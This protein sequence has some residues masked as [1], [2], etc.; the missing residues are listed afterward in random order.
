MTLWQFLC[1]G[2]QGQKSQYCNKKTKQESA[3]LQ[4]LELNRRVNGVTDRYLS[5][6]VHQQHCSHWPLRLAVTLLWLILGVG[7]Q[8]P[9]Q[10]TLPTHR[11]TSA[12]HHKFKP[13]HY[14]LIKIIF[15]IERQRKQDYKVVEVAAEINCRI[16]R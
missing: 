7:F 11:H 14:A 9:E 5:R 4:C 13:S 1:H 2:T 8:H 15:R 6:H 3:K 10:T 12:T 16:D